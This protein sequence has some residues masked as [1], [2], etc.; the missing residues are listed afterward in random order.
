MWYVVT[1]RYMSA[2]PKRKLC[3]NIDVIYYFA[4]YNEIYE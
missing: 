3:T 2:S 4:G 1:P